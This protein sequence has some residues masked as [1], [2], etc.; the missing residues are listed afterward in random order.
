MRVALL[1]PLVSPI[2]E[3][4]IGGVATLL[5][6]LAAG[7]VAAGHEVDLFAASGS[8]VDGLPIVDTG[9]DASALAGTL[10]R[11][12][13]PAPRPADAAL[14]HEAFR[15]A[16]ALVAEGSY[17][18]VHNH[19]FDAPAIALAPQSG[20]PVVHTI[21]LPP[22]PAVAEALQAAA[23][24]PRPPVVAAVSAS[25][26]RGW[27]RH[28][29]I[30]LVL[31]PGVP[32]A[33]IPWTDHAGPGLLVAGRLSPEKGVLQAIAMARAAGRQL[34]VAGGPY[35]PAYAAEV[36]REAR[37]GGV[38]LA[39]PLPRTQVWELM[40]RSSCL[41]FPV[42]WQEPFGMVG[43]EAQAAG[44]P[45]IGFRGGALPDVILDGV[46]GALVEVGDLTAAHAALAGLEGLDRAACRAHAERSLDLTPMIAAHERLYARMTGSRAAEPGRGG[47]P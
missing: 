1:A 47:D 31:Q 11:P 34:V 6:D 16:Y 24:R 46:T 40:G 17:D 27:E 41:L 36:E 4:Q 28:A 8:A 38:V 33:R 19:A 14:A 5:T 3:P 35:D 25:Q 21:H 32:T 20:P 13:G 23:R 7:L 18:V 42:L 2:R 12:M 22:A 43:A 39:G 44:C 15:A 9:V 29:R 30:D 26:R 10:F 45:V 37:A